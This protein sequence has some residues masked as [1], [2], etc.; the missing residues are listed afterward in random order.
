MEFTS[1]LVMKSILNWKLESNHDWKTALHKSCGQCRFWPSRSS[2][3]FNN[4]GCHS[5]MRILNAFSN[6]GYCVASH[7]A[8]S[9][10]QCV[11][12]CS[13]FHTLMENHQVDWF[14]KLLSNE[15]ETTYE[16]CTEIANSWIVQPGIEIQ[17]MTKNAQLV[18]E[19]EKEID[20]P[21]HVL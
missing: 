5:K 13:D 19:L 6:V 3:C 16:Q 7:S 20:Y 10:H 8:V 2:L 17:L 9:S 1:K 15:V 14:L 4:G 11:Q 18:L 21:E 12:Q